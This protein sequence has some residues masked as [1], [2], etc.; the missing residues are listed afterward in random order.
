[1]ARGRQ[2]EAG[3][4]ITI[5]LILIATILV[6]GSLVG[7]VAIR[8]ALVKR[9]AHRESQQITVYDAN[10]IWLGRAIGFDEHQAPLVPYIDRT[11]PPESPDP[12]HLDYRALIGVRDDRFTSREPVYYDGLDCTGTPCIKATSDET[13]DNTGLSGL[14][15]TGAVSYLHALQ[16][17]PNYA[18]GASPDGIQGRLYRSTFQACPVAPADIQS[19][20]LSQKVVTGSPCENRTTVVAGGPTTTTTTTTGQAV[21]TAYCD[22]QA[23][24]CTATAPETCTCITE[25]TVLASCAD[26]DSQLAV[27]DAIEADV[28][29][30]SSAYLDTLL[31]LSNPSGN[32]TRFLPDV[33]LTSVD[34]MDI[35]CPVGSVLG[36]V[37]LVDTAGYLILINE[38]LEAGLPNGQ[39][40]FL[41]E[42]LG[43][44]VPSTEFSCAGEP[45]P[46]PEVE[47][48][49]SWGGLQALAAEPVPDP[50]DPAANALDRFLAPFRVQLPI[51]MAAESWISTPPDGV[52]GS[53]P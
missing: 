37:G 15:A 22:N 4:I 45:A 28:L 43:V 30:R 29:Q 31:T 40:T 21:T 14:P 19:R 41:L 1:M 32:Y 36:Q 44:Q 2:S 20:Y 25:P 17:G 49:I 24:P 10:G 47:Q 9:I 16:G 53:A 33:V 52:E 7:L 13:A 48:S 38:L 11:V 42:D 18:I 23:A 26:G 3:F 51:G 12:A 5:E 35:C 34:G 6:I 46:P 50:D 8:D 27:L 39:L